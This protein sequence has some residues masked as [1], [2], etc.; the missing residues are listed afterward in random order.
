MNK[1]L[2]VC[3]LVAIPSTL[4]T[5]GVDV[6]TAVG[7]A[8]CMKQAGMAFLISRGYR[9]VGGIDPAAAGNI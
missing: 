5:I 8:A 3:L 1:I 4:A 7:N 9:Q 2:I 6:S